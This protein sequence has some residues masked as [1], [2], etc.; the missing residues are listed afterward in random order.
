MGIIRE[1]KGVDFT[2]INREMTAEERT[3]LSAF[4]VQEKLRIAKLKKRR[5]KAAEKRA[6]SKSTMENQKS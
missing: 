1:P 5:E 2:V 3:A 6:A 4:I